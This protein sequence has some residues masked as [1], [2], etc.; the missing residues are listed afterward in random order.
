MSSGYGDIQELLKRKTAQEAQTST[1]S[2]SD[3]SMGALLQLLTRGRGGGGA[4]VDNYQTPRSRQTINDTARGRLL[5]K[6]DPDTARKNLAAIY[7][8]YGSSFEPQ[9]SPQL[10][11]HF[12]DMAA[13]ID[14][15]P[16]LASHSTANKA[17]RRAPKSGAMSASLQTRGTRSEDARSQARQAT[18][19]RLEQELAITELKK[20]IEE[21]NKPNPLEAIEEQR[22]REDLIFTKDR[23]D[24][25]RAMFTKLLGR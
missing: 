13:A 22:A 4:R 12:R 1:P 17:A 11:A 6:L 9:R 15:T 14:P 24:A 21:A 8:V 3:M 7:R 19:G 18:L 23:Q 5:G 16:G 10:R 20:R 25:V 2:D